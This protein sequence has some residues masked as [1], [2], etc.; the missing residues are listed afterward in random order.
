VAKR[1]KI[2]EP[3]NDAE[4]WGFELLE[5]ELPDTHLLVTNVELPTSTG[6]LLEIDAIVFGDRAIYLLDIKGYSGSLLVDPNVWL[7][8]Q[9]RIANPLSKANQI[10]RIYAGRM[11]EN[12]LRDEHAPWCQGM[13]FVTGHRGESLS[14]KKSQDTLSV[15][16]PGDIIRGLTDEL[17]VTAPG[18]YAISS[19]QRKKALDVLGR[20]GKIPDGPAEVAGFNRIRRLSSEEGIEVWE[21]TSHQGELRS[22]W[23]LKEVDIT[24]GDAPTQLAAE[25]LKSEYIRYQQLHGIPG[26]AS[27]APLISDGERLLLPVRMPAGLPLNEIKP[28]SL[29]RAAAFTALRTLI[30]AVEQFQSRD[31]GNVV[32]A[33]ETVYIDELGGV[34]LLA[35]GDYADSTATAIDALEFIWGSLKD[36]IQSAA[37]AS[38]FTDID[39]PPDLN[40]LRFLIASEIAGKTAVAREKSVIAQGE[41]LLGRYKLDAQLEEIATV[42]TWKALHEAGKFPL[43]CTVVKNATER[44]G[45][46]Q[47]RLAMLMQNFHPNI[48]RIFDIE[49]LPDDDIYLVNRAW[50]DANPLDTVEEPATAVQVLAKALAALSYLHSLDILH[51]RICPDHILVQ[52]DHPILISLSAL[53][54]DELIDSMPGYVHASVAE[55]G[56]SPRADLWALVKSFIDTLGALI[57]QGDQP[58]YEKLS[59]FI[60]DPD[61]IPHGLDY[62]SYFDLKPR[63]S[64]TEVPSA[65]ADAWAI[66]KGYMTFLVL[67]MINDNRPRSRNRIVLTALRSR[68]IAGNKINRSSMNST[69]SRLKSAGIAEDH[70]KKVRLTDQ[71]LSA[72]SEQAGGF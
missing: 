39:A 51:R 58:A 29:D 37:I 48:E 64:V 20:L 8:D 50:V 54:R 67:D 22:D 47:R 26:M 38:W 56:W 24:A 23:L 52:E 30:S 42:E 18:K 65:L 46:A 62:L 41:V 5:R 11:R 40:E 68:H 44:W 45:G 35:S 6:Q 59:A 17:Y 13:V 72:W 9:K 19:A 32:P 7:L 12:L 31:L 55:E 34:T 71:F 10:A 43:V 16:G 25:S 1:I 36:S 61:T 4:S 33:S 70:G 2:G 27:C 69:V 3:V 28:G 57:Q 14:L 53:P 49:Y 60:E 15:F 21:A 66:S 63:E